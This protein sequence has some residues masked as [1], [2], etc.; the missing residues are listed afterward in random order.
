[1]KLRN[2]ILATLPAI[3]LAGCGSN[4]VNL[5]NS[6]A[7]KEK[8]VAAETN[9]QVVEKYRELQTKEMTV[10]LMKINAETDEA[11]EELEKVYRNSEKIIMAEIE[12]CMRSQGLVRGR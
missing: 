9:C 2:Q 12:E 10:D 5:D 8:I 7:S 1:M 3:A 6:G 4:W 11:K